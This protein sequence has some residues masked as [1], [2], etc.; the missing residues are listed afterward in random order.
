M[1]LITPEFGTIF[2]Q[3]IIF[4]LVLLVLRKFAWKV[5]LSTIKTREDAITSAL[6]S[7]E[8]AKTALEGLQEKSSKLIE[9]AHVE[10]EKLL[11]EAV[12]LKNEIIQEAKVEA[13]KMGQKIVSQA[14]ESIEK[15]KAKARQDLK[16]HIALLALQV[17]ESLLKKELKDRESHESLVNSLM[18]DNQ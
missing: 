15:E 3:A 12:D 11:K 2:W 8:E 4:L 5:I 1:D 10:R 7:A 16:Q 13:E 6:L 18:D 17:T 14:K 9:Q